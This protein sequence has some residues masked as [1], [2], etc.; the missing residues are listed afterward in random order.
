[1]DTYGTG[2]SHKRGAAS[3]GIYEVIHNHS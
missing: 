3:K 1:M 2:S